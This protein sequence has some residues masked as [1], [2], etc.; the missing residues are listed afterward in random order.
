MGEADVDERS[1]P[2]EVDVAGGG[3]RLVVADVQSVGVTELAVGARAPAAHPA[4]LEQRAGREITGSEHFDGSAD[5]DVA[6]RRRRL[7]VADGSSI[8]VA[9]PAIVTPL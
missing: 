5:V 1:D 4:G 7:V 8:A 3:R 2:A 9:E 6:H